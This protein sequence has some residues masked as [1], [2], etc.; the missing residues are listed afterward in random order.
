MV[1]DVIIPANINSPELKAMT[2]K[3]IQSLSESEDYVKFNVT[4][5]LDDGVTPFCYNKSL[6]MGLEKGD[7]EFVILANND[8]IYEKNFFSE[9]M[10]A[11]NAGI[12]E[13]FGCWNPK[14]H[15]R[16]FKKE[17]D[18]YVGDRIG[19]ELT[20]W[21]IV[22][23]RKVLEKIN[24]CHRDSFKVD[25]WYSDDLY[26]YLLRQH[27]IKHALVRNS[28]VTHL[29]SKTLK[30]H[31]KEKQIELTIGQKKKYDAGKVY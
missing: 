5:V 6:C 9:L 4:L 13:S 29:L 1:V 14:W 28:K 24:F 18:Y 20:G 16:F 23:T 25:F 15:E 30:T 31:S 22:T 26:K 11:Y 10:I 8:L 3:S 21:I 7:S 27:N 12:A 19:Y 2:E 17:Q